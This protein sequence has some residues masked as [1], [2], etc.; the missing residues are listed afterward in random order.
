MSHSIGSLEKELLGLL[1]PGRDS[2]IAAR[3]YGFDGRGG[4]T[5][6]SV[7]EEYRLTR[8]R[9]RQIV[10]KMKG[11][12]SDQR[13]ISPILDRTVALV[14]NRLPAA[15]SEIEAE[16]KLQGLSSSLFRL[17]GVIKAAELLGK[18]VQFVITAGVAGKR[19]VHA[20]GSPSGRTIIRIARRLIAHR[21]MATVSDVVVKVRGVMSG[22][23]D[24]NLVAIA[25]AQEKGFAWLDRS[26][27]WFWLSESR[28]NPV[29]SRI[30]KILSVAKAVEV[31]E[32]AAGIARDFRMDDF[33]PPK[34][35]LLEFC[36]Q[37]PG[38]Q[39]RDSTIKANPEIKPD[40]VLTQ[41]EKDIG[42]ILAEHGGT[43]ATWELKSICFGIG[44]NR[45]CLF[46]SLLYSPI[47]SEEAGGLYRLIGSKE[48]TWY[49]A[50]H[51]R[52]RAKPKIQSEYPSSIDTTVF[53]SGLLQ[54]QQVSTILGI[55]P[56]AVHYH[57]KS[58]SLKGKKIGSK[59]WHFHI[60]D[61]YEF[62]QR[63][64]A[65]KL[66]GLSRIRLTPSDDSPVS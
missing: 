12:F 10:E 50:T 36:R 18:P 24:K 48:K 39:V 27:G 22:P 46:R 26:A 23:C 51:R 8:E 58:G 6:M 57:A 61:V 7:G 53:P 63:I 1:G 54:V 64:N 59:H 2:Q 11:R 38:L 40:Q 45:A 5:L 52:R 43:L 3:Y 15:A 29:L 44:I 41:S 66:K 9:V 47:I 42:Q 21:G 17:E 32:L 14:A 28:I 37:A 20:Q 35:V 16:L 62:K 55:S 56:R 60:L 4:K 30:R 19:I 34:R 25:L 33:S 13:P 31:S 49:C 65:L